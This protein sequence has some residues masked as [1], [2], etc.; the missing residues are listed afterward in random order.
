[1][2]KKA[3]KISKES[4]GSI[5]E[6]LNRLKTFL[7]R[8]KGELRDI[9]AKEDKGFAEKAREILIINLTHANQKETRSS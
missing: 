4:T 2:R 8:R 1:M 5:G 6:V 9:E 7:L 3:E